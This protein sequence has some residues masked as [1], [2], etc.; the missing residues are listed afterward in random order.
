MRETLCGSGE[1]ADETPSAI[2]T[3][4]AHCRQSV[5]QLGKWRSHH[6]PEIKRPSRQEFIGADASMALGDSWT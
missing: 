1:R 3:T 2:R 6:V 4:G 5:R